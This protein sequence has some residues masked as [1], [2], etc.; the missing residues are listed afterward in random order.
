MKADFVP[1]ARTVLIV[2]AV[3]SVL[4]VSA[5]NLSPPGGAISP[6][7]KDLDDV[8]PRTAIRNDFDTITPIVISSPGSY[9]LAEDIF[10]IHSEHGIEIDASHVTLDLNGFTVFGNTEVGSLDGIHI[11]DERHN[12]TIRNGTVRDFFQNGI[13]GTASDGCV[14]EGV[15]VINNSLYGIRLR[16][17]SRVKDCMALG[18]AQN[19]GITVNAK[20][21]ITGSLA[22]DNGN[23][24]SDAGIRVGADSGTVFACTSSENTGWG[25]RVG[26]GSTISSCTARN[27]TGN[28]LDASSVGHVVDS[29][30]TDN[31]INIS[32]TSAHNSFGP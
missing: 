26:S 30:A 16:N 8:E 10:S 9:Y 13:Y 18:N 21:V 29:T 7:M 19:D 17:Y 6:S 20:S 22:W 32:A 15:R 23:D 4:W 14:V 28:G 25:I 5:G 27:N 12:V 31:A 24:D 3:A 11:A 2:T 1:M